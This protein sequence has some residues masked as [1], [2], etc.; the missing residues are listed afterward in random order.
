MERIIANLDRLTHMTNLNL[1]INLCDV[2]EI[3]Y[4]FLIH[5]CTKRRNS[6]IEIRHILMSTNGIDNFVHKFGIKSYRELVEEACSEM[7]VTHFN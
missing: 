2:K 3:E 6:N 1:L 7:I 4:P 5:F